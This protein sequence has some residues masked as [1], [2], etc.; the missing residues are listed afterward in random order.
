MNRKIF[1]ILVS[2]ALIFTSCNREIKQF[3]GNYSYKLS[4]EVSIVGDDGEVSYRLVH[5]NGQMNILE[6]KSQAN[7]LIITMNEMN[8]GCYTISATV[9]G[10]SIVFLPY[11]FSTN[12][13]ISD[14]NLDIIS[15]D[16][17]PSIVY[18]I[19]ASGGGQLNDDILMI[20][21]QWTGHQSGNDTVLLNGPKMKIIAERN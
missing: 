17:T 12:I 9:K 20:D 18:A 19:R 1:W 4:G 6:D 3:T 8:G 21:E 7:R 11:E 2:A 14:S 15:G 16:N 13:L 5:K 10:D